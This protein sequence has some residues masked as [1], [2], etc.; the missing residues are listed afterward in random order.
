MKNATVAILVIGL[1]GYLSAGT[2]ITFLVVSAGTVVN[3]LVRSA[4]RKEDFRW[5]V[6]FHKGCATI[7][8]AFISFYVFSFDSLR[9]FSRFKP[10]HILICTLLISG[11]LYVMGGLKTQEV[12]GKENPGFLKTKDEKENASLA[13]TSLLVALIF[14]RVLIQ[15]QPIIK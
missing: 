9:T 1:I 12:L 3:S 7:H 11:F 5:R 8:W 15:T 4:F 13:T 6:V 2:L 14:A 10:I